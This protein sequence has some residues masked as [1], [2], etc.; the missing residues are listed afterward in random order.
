ME[1]D[2]WESVPEADPLI[3]EA[4][5]CQ[6]CLQVY[7][8]LGLGV[9][10]LAAAGLSLGIGRAGSLGAWAD[11]S[12]IFL[13][14]LTLVGGVVV[15]AATVGAAIGVAWMARALPEQAGR[16]RRGL[17]RVPPAVR[18]AGDMSAAPILWIRSGVSAVRTGWQTLLSVFQAE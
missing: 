1:T 8:P 13:L 2:I 12:L 6:V 5:R 10:C 17:A 4:H 15:L 9:L 14:T 11:V 3:R 7:L 18:R 16:L